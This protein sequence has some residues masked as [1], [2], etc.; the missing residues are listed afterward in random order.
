MPQ[1]TDGTQPETAPGRPAIGPRLIL[2]IIASGLLSFAGVVIETAMNVAFPALMREFG[3]TTDQVQWVTTGYL[4]VLAIIVPASSFLK[5]RFTTR[6]LFVTATTAFLLGLVLAA[7]APSFFVLLLGRLLQGFGTGIS[8]PLMF[9][10]VLEQ[11]PIENLGMMMGVASVITAL[12]PAVGPSLGGLVIQYSGWRM[13]FVVLIPVIA[14]ALAVGLA[15][16]RQFSTIEPAAFDLPGWLLLA[17]GLGGII[18]A[19]ATAASFGWSAPIVILAFAIGTISLV[20]FAR[21][22][23]NREDCIVRAAVFA[24]PAFC[25]SV[26]VVGLVQF[27]VL[28]LGYLIP[29]TAQ[30]S[31]GFGELLAGCLLLPG[32]ALGAVIA[33][34]SGRILDRLGGRLPILTGCAVVLAS[35]ILFSWSI[36]FGDGWP[37]LLSAG[38]TAAIYLLFATGQGFSIPTSMTNGLRQLPQALGTDG[39]AVFTTIQQV[40]GALGT[41]VAAGVMAQAQ[42][43]SGRDLAA[44]TL[45]GAGRSYL[46]LIAVAILALACAALG[47]RTSRRSARHNNR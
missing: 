46:L 37:A 24:H 38:I 14:I 20:C 6:S 25:W 36:R 15:T 18:I 44:A 7:V 45:L 5:R 34:T 32:C 47:F 17:F 23:Q 30:L 41:A 16:I 35:T 12:A 42:A 2:A 39:N 33:P 1:V 10:I 26:G 31:W 29:N 4:L 19:T 40:A 13:L 11:V 28:A 9:N 27:I 3:I 21:Y 8:L 43:T 22:S